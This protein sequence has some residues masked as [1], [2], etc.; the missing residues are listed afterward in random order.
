MSRRGR[1]YH[2]GGIVSED[3]NVNPKPLP[4][5]MAPLPDFR[6]APTENICFT[7][8]NSTSIVFCISKNGLFLAS[9]YTTYLEIHH[10]PTISSNWSL[11]Y[12][13]TTFTQPV[14]ACISEDGLTVAAIRPGSLGIFK[15]INGQWTQILLENVLIQ[16][17]LTGA[18][19]CCMNSNASIICF[20][21][22]GSDKNLSSES[23]VGRVWVYSLVNNQYVKTQTLYGDSEKGQ[24]FGN[25][26]SMSEDGNTLAVV[27]TDYKRFT[28]T[29]TITSHR[30]YGAL[31]I[32]KRHDNLLVNVAL[33]ENPMKPPFL[34]WG[35]SISFFSNVKMSPLGNLIFVSSIDSDG[36]VLYYTSKDNN[37]WSSLKIFHHVPKLVSN[38]HD[39]A[40]DCTIDECTVVISLT[41][42]LSHYTKFILYVYDAG[43]DPSQR[44]PRNLKLAQ[45]LIRNSVSQ[46]RVI[47]FEPQKWRTIL[48]SYP[49]GYTSI[50]Y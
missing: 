7:I 18:S 28:N 37:V 34:P 3:R 1:I 44:N 15:R 38:I 19:R 8:T 21:D 4:E 10:R 39:L 14:A 33:L 50:G 32:Y 13:S 35:Y 42:F 49:Y 6:T 23:L 36:H 31:Y 48:L 26:I 27:A 2:S 16:T 30:I 45:T 11:H 40:C 5:L 17:N 41:F 20:S 24:L 43:N 46:N 22:P 29:W 9:V 25:Y 12:I 47:M